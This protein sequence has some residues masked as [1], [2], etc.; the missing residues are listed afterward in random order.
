MDKNN[1]LTSLR[2]YWIVIGTIIVLVFLAGCGDFSP[3]DETSTGFFNEKFVYPFSLLIKW[4]A[5]LLNGSYGLAIIV[6]TIALRLVIMPFMIKQQKQSQVSQEV[7]QVL[8][9][10]ME[11]IQERYKGKESMEDQM[12]MQ[13]ELSELYQK[14]NFNPASTLLGCLPMLIQMPVLIAF[15]YAIRK[16]PEI[17]T[18]SFLWFSL[19]EV[20]VIIALIAVAIYYAQARVSLIGLEQKPEGPMALFPYISPIMIGIISFT[21]PA[22]LP[23]YWSVSGSF[24]TI[25]T[26][27]TKKFIL[28]K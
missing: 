20:D 24:I 26:F 15:Y 22:A 16:T 21:L 17:A 23:L 5:R 19:G 2:K 1:I 25:Q 18:H 6:I 27:I 10:E 12:A 3:I 28:T 9:P 7:M 13:Q 8:K 4:I 14:H 11:E